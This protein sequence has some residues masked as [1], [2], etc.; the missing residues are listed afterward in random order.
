MEI[1]NKGRQLG[2]LSTLI[3]GA[4]LSFSINS[5]AAE[6]DHSQHQGMDHSQHAGMDHSKHAQAA[7]HVHHQHGAGQWM[8]EFRWMRMEMEGLL[9][10]DDGVSTFEISGANMPAVMGGMPTNNMN[11]PYMM[12]PRKMTMDMK[13]LMLM[14]GFSDKL[15]G[16]LMFNHLDNEMDMVMHMYNTAGTMYM[17]DM[18]STMETSG[19]GDTQVGVM[20][21]IDSNLTASV[22]L[23]IPTGDID[24]KV[25]MMGADRQAPYA[26][27]L[28]T[29]TYDLIPGIQ[30][31]Q[32]SGN[33]TYGAKGEY[34]MH[35]GENDNDYT[36]GDK[37]TLSGW[38]K[39][40]INNMWSIAGRID[41][42]DQDEIDGADPMLSTMMAQ[43]M[44]PTNRTENYGGTRIDLT[45]DATAATGPHNFG[46]AFTRPVKY[47]LNGVQMKLESIVTL[48]YMYMM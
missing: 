22:M 41:Y 32:T 35:T 47:D 7:S 17:M 10:G 13:M 8:F 23:S 29:G 25:E 26:M 48:S 14:Y 1:K 36:W 31:T 44:S 12:A 45:V 5:T 34:R 15:S 27:Q 38:A 9:S 6:M 40:K 3:G 37:L 2:I 43:M 39:N 18:T 46:L 24:E 4:M 16:M 42:M 21:N 28:G 33:M 20:Y 19:I 30:Y 11:T